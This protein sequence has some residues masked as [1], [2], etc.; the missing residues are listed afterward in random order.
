MANPP[1]TT[2]P[3]DLIGRKLGAA[4][5]K[6]RQGG[7]Q[8][9][10]PL[11]SKIEPLPKPATDAPLTPASTAADPAIS[12]SDGS[13]SRVN[14]TSSSTTDGTNSVKQGTSEPSLVAGQT[15]IDPDQPTIDPA[16]RMGGTTGSEAA[17]RTVGR[18]IEAYSRHAS[19]IDPAGQLGPRI[20]QALYGRNQIVSVQLHPAELG[21]VQIR[22][23]VDASRK[24]RAAISAEQ[25]ETMELLQRHTS[26]IER[27]LTATGLTLADTDG[28]TFNLGTPQDRGTSPGSQGREDDHLSSNFDDLIDLTPLGTSS[29][30]Q[31]A[32][33]GLLDL[34]L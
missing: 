14:M 17:D 31:A 28:L 9:P 27:A 22:I 1:A 33:T 23:V 34:I 5:A 16:H 4:P 20:A 18:G 19:A 2:R 12:T 13:A 8:P 25:P 30:R 3:G 29:P 24:V 15:S 21:I 6:T 26:G 11:V 10:T 32:S 7:P